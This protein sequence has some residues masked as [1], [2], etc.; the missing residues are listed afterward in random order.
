MTGWQVCVGGEVVS[1][2]SSYLDAV[3]VA[4]SVAARFERDAGVFGVAGVV[5]SCIVR[6]DGSVWR[7]VRHSERMAAASGSGVVA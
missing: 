4:G 2:H 1:T 5:P 6:A 7:G 3:A